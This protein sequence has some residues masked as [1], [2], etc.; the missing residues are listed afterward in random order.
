[1][2]RTLVYQNLHY[3]QPGVLRFQNTTKIGIT[4]RAKQEWS[5]HLVSVP[6][7]WGKAFSCLAFT[8]SRS[9]DHT[10]DQS[11]H[12][13]YTISLFYSSLR[14]NVTCDSRQVALVHCRQLPLS[15]LN[16]PEVVH[17]LRSET[18]PLSLDK[19]VSSLF[20][21]TVIFCS[22]SMS[23]HPKSFFLCLI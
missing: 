3:L 19:E 22:E 8:W 6:S 18:F 14:P 21:P 9:H 5:F 2:K 17:S 16:S 11:Y 12:L 23:K 7:E 10:T 13:Q 4:K 20:E 1:M 15:R